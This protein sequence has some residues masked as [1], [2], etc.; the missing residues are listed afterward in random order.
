MWKR[1]C[2]V[3]FIADHIIIGKDF[4]HF[5][6]INDKGIVGERQMHKKEAVTWHRM[7]PQYRL[8]NTWKLDSF[9]KMTAKEFIFDNERS[10]P[11][12]AIS[13]IDKFLVSQDLDTRGGRIEATTSV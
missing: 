10:G 9:L 12:L 1:L 3:C 4:N 5:K 7:I 8:S 2:E 11:S 6:E 13:H